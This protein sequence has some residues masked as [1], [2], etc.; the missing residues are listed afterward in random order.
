[1]SPYI[2]SVSAYN[3]FTGQGGQVMGA[4]SM[5]G[6]QQGMQAAANYGQ[7][8]A[9]GPGG[10]PGLGGNAVYGGGGKVSYRS[11]FTPAG[12]QPAGAPASAG[13]PGLQGKIESTLNKQLDAPGMTE[14]EIQQVV[15]KG[16]DR[17]SQEQMSAKMQAREQAEAA[18]FGQSGSM[19]AGQQALDDSFVG[20]R[21]EYEQGVRLDAAKDRSRMQANAVSQAS[22]YLDGER[23]RADKAGA[24]LPGLNG[25]NGGFATGAKGSDAMAAE[26]G[27]ETGLYTD[28]GRSGRAGGANLGK[29]PGWAKMFA[30][31]KPRLTLAGS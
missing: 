23:D 1:M 21:N 22:N 12:A 4:S 17:M 30:P 16:N 3:K 25:M 27:G 20:K 9:G 15:N 24:R 13:L 11:G 29:S 14:N 10:P 31:S 7:S 18:G 5:G 2:K 28:L 26:F 19:M 6:L 8:G